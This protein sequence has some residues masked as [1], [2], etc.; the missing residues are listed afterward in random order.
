V[1]PKPFH[2]REEVNSMRHSSFPLIGGEDE[3]GNNDHE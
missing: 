1:P 2:A 3:D